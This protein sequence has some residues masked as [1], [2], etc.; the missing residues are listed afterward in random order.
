LRADRAPPLQGAKAAGTLNCYTDGFAGFRC[1]FVTGDVSTSN[2]RPAARRRSPPRRGTWARV[3]A[4]LIGEL[5]LLEEVV[6]SLLDADRAAVARVLGDLAE[7]VDAE[8]HR[9]MM[10]HHGSHR[11]PAS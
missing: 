2:R 9:R 7:R 6:E 10:A 1:D 3:E 4:D 5:D 11:R 8:F